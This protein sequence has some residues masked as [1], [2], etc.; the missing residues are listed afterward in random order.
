M[1]PYQQG[2]ADFTAGRSFP[3]V[4]EKWRSEAQF[5]YE[6]GRLMAARRAAKSFLMQFN[7][8]VRELRRA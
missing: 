1:T 7:E 8:L 6:R 4:Y 5:S 2:V 3:P